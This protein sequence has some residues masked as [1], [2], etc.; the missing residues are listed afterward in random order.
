MVKRALH[1]P[2]ADLEAALE[3]EARDVLVCR[4]T[5]DWAEGVRSFLE[6]RRPEFRGR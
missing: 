1:D 2:P 5:G 3:A 4:E 6:K